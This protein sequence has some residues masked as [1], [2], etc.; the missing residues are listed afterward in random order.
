MLVRTSFEAGLQMHHGNLSTAGAN[1]DSKSQADKVEVSITVPVQTPAHTFRTSSLLRY[2][3]KNPKKR[4]KD[5]HPDS[6]AVDR[7]GCDV[8]GR[9]RSRAALVALI[10][11][12]LV[13]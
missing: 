5:N 7:A 9:R 4:D 11:R 6:P 10:D 1:P 8:V 13:F 2:S 3:P 12:K